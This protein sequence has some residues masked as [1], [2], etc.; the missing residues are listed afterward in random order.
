[1]IN[2]KKRNPFI[3]F[4]LSLFCPGLGFL[5]ITKTKLF[6][7]YISLYFSLF[8]LIAVFKNFSL[9]R[10][11]LFLFII[12]ILLNLASLVIPVILSQRNRTAE[13]KKYNRLYFYLAFILFAAIV[14]PFLYNNFI[15][16]RFCQFPTSSMLP[17]IRVNERIAIDTGFSP[18]RSLKRGDIITFMY[19]NTI[20]AK[21]C[22]AISGD[23]FELK[24][25]IV[26]INGKKHDE[27]YV[28]FKEE[29]IDDFINF[30]DDV[31]IING[32]VPEGKCIVLGDNRNNSMD[33]REFGYVDYNDISG[34]A[35]FIYFSD[36]KSRI[37]K[38]L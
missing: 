31:I 3:A 33:S 34:K 16:I 28:E 32:I 10:G 24:N 35:M 15:Q 30:E 1:M 4:I 12:S 7:I 19:K 38:S 9:Y 2:L 8:C 21:R 13:L 18:N 27:P 26:F 36:I 22:I 14:I 37:G 17:T 20:Q 23:R 29:N 25:G 6:L 5:F 11:L